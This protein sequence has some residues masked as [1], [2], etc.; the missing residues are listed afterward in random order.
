[1]KVVTSS[2][3]KRLVAMEVAMGVMVTSVSRVLESCLVG[4]MT[5]QGASRIV[6]LDA[7]V[8][9]ADQGNDKAVEALGALEQLQSRDDLEF[10]RLWAEGDG[11][12]RANL[13]LLMYLSK[14]QAEPVSNSRQSVDEDHAN[15]G[16]L[17]GSFGGG[18]L[19]SHLSSASH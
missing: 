8:L 19:G 13:S 17:Y 10:M 2:T 18:D 14:K 4:P 5:T 15:S 1:M 12:I 9:I 16:V 7:E 6:D 3:A 11:H